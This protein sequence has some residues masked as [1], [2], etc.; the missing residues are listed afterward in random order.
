M[1]QP[2]HQGTGD[3]E[4]NWMQLDNGLWNPEDGVNFNDPIMQLEYGLWDPEP[5]VGFDENFP[6]TIVSQ[7]P[8]AGDEAGR[9]LYNH[10]NNFVANGSGS[11][12]YTG[13]SIPRGGVA[14]TPEQVQA[15]STPSFQ[16]VENNMEPQHLLSNVA[17]AEKDEDEPEYVTHARTPPATK[18]ARKSAG[19]SSEEWQKR[20]PEIYNLYV[21]AGYKLEATRKQ[22]AD[23]GF[24]AESVPLPFLP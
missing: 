23:N 13:A 2:A 5:N 15:L 6:N 9:T 1:A 11:G 21:V 10:I 19:P 14:L 3:R 18:R 12:G 8:I 7:H 24:Q 20:K 22:M 17:S 4:D 16:V